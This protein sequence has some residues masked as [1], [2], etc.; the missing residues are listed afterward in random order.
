MD[1]LLPDQW[2]FHERESWVWILDRFVPY[3]FQL[4]IH[5]L[6]PAAQKE[7][8]DGL[9]AAHK[10]AP[11]EK[12]KNF[13]EWIMQ[14]SGTGIAKYFLLP[15][16]FKVWAHYPHD[17]NAVWVGERVA[18]TDLERVK[19]N[20]AENRDDVAWGPN[21][22]FRFPVKGGTGAI[23]NALADKV[24]RTKITFDYE[25]ETID[26]NQHTVSFKNGQQ[27]GYE[28]LIS[29]I[30]LD[31]LVQHSDLP[32]QLKQTTQKLLH[33]TT[34]IVGIGLAGK[35]QAELS[36]K[37]WMYFP[38]D[39]CPFYRVTLFSKYSPNNVPDD[40]KNW[41]LMTE[42]S[43]SAYK[44]VDTKNLPQQVI[45][46]LKNTKLISPTDQIVSTWQYQ[47][48]YGYPVPSLSRDEALEIIQ[49]E[50]AK[51]NIYSR[52]RFGMWKYEVS[53]QDHTMMQGKEIA[54][55]LVNHTPELTAWHPN[56]VNGGKKI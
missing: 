24:G 14:T 28:H 7:C 44:P 49:P 52:G 46:G 3:P 22:T 18:V 30:P 50:L 1:Q 4:N 10:N 45:A 42:V 32:E 33:T 21:N 51:K 13:E 19:K 47:T 48:A 27:V 41:S 34:H 56:V 5:R 23:W 11:T 20:I 39:N 12:P 31:V 38:E 53:N 43:E 40:T 36:E 55:F 35:P 26:T 37:C 17:M 8:L 9:I 2:I 6:P 29:T 15:Y 54:D 25:V 16:N